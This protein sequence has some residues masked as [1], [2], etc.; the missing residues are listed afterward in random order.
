MHIAVFGANGLTGRLLVQQALDA[1]YEVVAA[2]RRPDEFPISHAALEVAKA[3][4]HD[5]ND[6]DRVVEGTDAVL[7]ALGVPF[8][9][10]PMNV[11]SDG[12]TNILES[13]T[14][15]GVKRVAAVSSTAVEPHHHADG[16]F[17]L[18]RIVQPIVSRTIGKTTY[19]DMRVMEEILRA[20]ALDWTIVRSAGLFDAQQV[21]EYAVSEGPLDGIFTSR[22]DLAACLLAQVADTQYVHQAIEINT[23]DGA[24]TLFEM[25]RREAFKKEKG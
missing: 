10:E 24:P 12:I 25:I 11:Y 17:M 22:A 6:V 18:N 20:S 8:A 15:F 21:S 5:G 13:M 3:D 4:V 14:R 2:T 1:G 9:R 19:A 7:S 16:G 23:L